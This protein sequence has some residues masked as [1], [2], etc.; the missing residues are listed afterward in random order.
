[1]QPGVGAPLQ[2]SLGLAP[3]PAL[4]RCLLDLI[5]ALAVVNEEWATILRRHYVDG[6]EVFLIARELSQVEG[7]INRKQ[8]LATTLLADLLQG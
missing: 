1:M 4:R 2:Q 7:T 5:D 8:R 6:V 3:A